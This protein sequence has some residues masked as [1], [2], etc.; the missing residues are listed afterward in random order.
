MHR[1][2]F[3][4]QVSLDLPFFSKCF[5]RISYDTS[6]TTTMKLNDIEIKGQSFGIQQV[7]QAKHLTKLEL[8]PCIK[9]HESSLC[10]DLE[11]LLSLSLQLN[12][13]LKILK[14][15]LKNVSLYDLVTKEYCPFFM[16]L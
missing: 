3:K 6:S 16:D 9:H 13:N 2:D 8:S 14:I 4:I 10:L 12:Q 15:F 1:I 7:F 11:Y 5:Q